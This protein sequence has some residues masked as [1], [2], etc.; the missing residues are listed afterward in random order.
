MSLNEPQI[1]T[2]HFDD[3]QAAYFDHVK[4]AKRGFAKLFHAQAKEEHEHF[5]KFLDYINLRSAYV[6]NFNVKVCYFLFEFSYVKSANMFKIDAKQIVMG[7][8]FGS[9]KGRHRT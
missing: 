2:I 5:E 6:A 1:Q 8:H 9:T 7:K 4:V 3:L